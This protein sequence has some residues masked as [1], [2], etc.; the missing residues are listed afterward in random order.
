MLSCN[1][2][3]LP[4]QVPQKS[5]AHPSHTMR[6][7]ACGVMW[8]TTFF[9]E[10]NVTD[11]VLESNTNPIRTAGSPRVFHSKRLF[12]YYGTTTMVVGHSLG[13]LVSLS[14]LLR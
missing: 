5:T 11:S 2:S 6:L 9:G 12:Q 1:N 7:G 4:S 8:V 13:G 14:C 10:S 3:R